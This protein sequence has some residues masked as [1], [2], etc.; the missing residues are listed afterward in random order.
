MVCSWSMIWLLFLQTLRV[1][2]YVILSVIWVC[3]HGGPVSLHDA[4]GAFLC[5]GTPNTGQ[6]ISLFHTFAEFRPISGLLCNNPNHYWLAAN[7]Q[8]SPNGDLLIFSGYIQTWGSLSLD[9]YRPEKLPPYTFPGL[10][11]LQ[12]LLHHP[13]IRVKNMYFVQG[14]GFPLAVFP[15]NKQL[16]SVLG[17]PFHRCGEQ[18]SL[19]IS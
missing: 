13:S 8:F 3:L 5:I 2:R 1:C 10:W 9:L 16:A 14:S 6:L 12:Y 4:L 15:T 17:T 7:A 18:F 19:L 11:T